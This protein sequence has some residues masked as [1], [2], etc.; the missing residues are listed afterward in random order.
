MTEQTAQRSLSIL[1]GTL[2]LC[3]LNEVIDKNVAEYGFRMPTK[4]KSRG[5]GT[6][7]LDQ[8]AAIW[9]E[10]YGTYAEAAYILYAFDGARSGEGLAPLLSE[11][12]EIVIDGYRMVS[13]PFMRQVDDRGRVSLDN[14]LKNVWSPRAS[15]LPQPFADRILEIKAEREAEGCVYLSDDGTGNPVPQKAIRAAYYEALGRVG[16]P[17]QQ[18]RALR[19]SWRSWIATVGINPEVIE[20][21][22][23]HV[24]YGTTGRHY[25][26][27]DK[28]LLAK[29]IHRVFS[30][31]PL[32]LE[33][34][35]LGTNR[36]TK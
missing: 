23:G 14:D 6:F 9:R 21:M 35:P 22:M 8:L 33:W 3:L 16:I 36:D 12:E 1:K 19:R 18:M 15:V 25:L 2:R 32:K 20:K 24:G 10:L 17:R 5:D 29:E 13:V 4:K 30:V 11:V 26:K 27:M 31:N 7:T 28:E 34:E